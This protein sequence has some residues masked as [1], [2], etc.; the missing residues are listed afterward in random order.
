M[1]KLLALLLASLMLVTAIPFSVAATD[2]AT[3]TESRTID[4]NWVQNYAVT[5]P[6]NA[7]YNGQHYIELSGYSTTEVFCVPS[8]GTTLTWSDDASTYADFDIAII[9]SWIQDENGDWIVDKDGAVFVGNKGN[10]ETRVATKKDSEGK[11]TYSYTTSKPNENLRLCIKSSGQPTISYTTNTDATGTWDY[12]KANRPKDPTS[13]PTSEFFNE[14]KLDVTKVLND[15]NWYYGYVGSRFNT[16]YTNKIYPNANRT[17]VYSDIITIPKAGTTVYFFDDAS[18]DQAGTAY[19]SGEE[20]YVFSTWIKSNNEW[21]IDTVDTDYK[22]IAANVM[23]QAKLLDGGGNVSGM[24]YYYTTVYDNQSIRLSYRAGVMNDC[25]ISPSPYNVLLV[26]NGIMPLVTTTGTL[27]S[28]SYTDSNNTPFNYKVYIPANCDFDTARTIFNMSSDET[29]ID[30]LIADNTDAIIFSFDGT[31]DDGARF[32]DTAVRNYG[33]NKHRMYLICSEDFFKLAK[34]RAFV[35]Y[36]TGADGYN[37]AL[38][39]GKA[40]LEGKVVYATESTYIEKEEAQESYYSELEGITMYAI[41][42]SYF[43]GYKL[44]KVYS[45]VSRMGDKYD[46]NYENYG[47]SGCTVA[48]NNGGINPIV[49]RFTGMAS[50]DADVILIEGG[51]ND[52]AT[53][54]DIT[55]RSPIGTNDSK[56]TTEFK[57]ALNVIIEG[58]LKKYPNAIIVLVTPWNHTEKY[59]YG[60]NVDYANA[61]KELAEYINSPRVFC[62]YAADPANVGGIDASN[63]TSRTNYFVAS[64]DSS[65]LNLEG[66]K[67]VQPYMEK[68]IAESL[69]SYNEYLTRTVV[70]ASIKN[71]STTIGKDLSLNIY[72]DISD[73]YV[74]GEKIEAND[75]PN[76]VTA[77]FTMNGKTVSG[78]KGELDSGNT[79]KFIFDGISPQCMGDEIDAKLVFNGEVVDTLEDKFTIRQYCIK[80]LSMTA[81]EM[82]VSEAKAKLI[83]TLAADLLEYGAAAQNYKGYKTD[84]LVNDG[85]DGASEFVPLTE[86]DINRNR[87]T[88][89]ATDG[90]EIMSAGLYFD[91]VNKLFFKFT[92]P[93]KT[94]VKLLINNKEAEFKSSGAENTYIVYTDAIYA[95]EFDQLYTVELYYDNTLVQTLTYDT[96]AYFYIMQN[97]VIDGTSELSPMAHLA[98]A[99]RNYSLSAKAYISYKPTT[100]FDGIEDTLN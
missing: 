64:N 40:L 50:G 44:G 5:S 84:A 24:M 80:L 68:F 7:A 18:K 27:T 70:T 62:M 59:T 86:N 53:E 19:I 21:V 29:I 61:M 36:I 25:S 33:I 78:V 51:R 87:L 32:I 55:K 16:S 3:E 20:Y 56:N 90:V 76:Y 6:L 13:A 67:L 2:S 75:I 83:K 37:S 15:V 81:K 60:S 48:N 72:A 66:M 88:V 96:A 17:H 57:G 26:E 4:T 9:S 58:C 10:Y 74:N 71:T 93:D 54:K 35:N 14:V 22:N 42:D 89:N 38:D 63:L 95:S 28:A 12:V 8:S 65:H 43:A 49:D 98:R 99:T 100:D 23:S 52:A 85:I 79:Y 34:P 11:V 31:N 77:T 97:N 30:A 41:G 73:C 46:M 47:I 92:A 94:K 91:S 82:E 1:K 45:W 39:A 69:N